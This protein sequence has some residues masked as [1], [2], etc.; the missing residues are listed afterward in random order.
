M[1]GQREPL[2]RDPR[3]AAPPWSQPYAKAKGEK[4]RQGGRDFLSRRPLEGALSFR[5]TFSLSEAILG[6]NLLMGKS[7]P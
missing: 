5:L 3:G 6:S 1:E 7:P 4:G 2:E